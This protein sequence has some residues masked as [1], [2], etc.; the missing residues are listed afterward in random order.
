MCSRMVV[1]YNLGRAIFG[2]LHSKVQVSNQCSNQAEEQ[3][4]AK[5]MRGVGEAKGTCILVKGEIDLASELY[6][7]C[8]HKT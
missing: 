3:R 4:A 8:T 7:V 5:R 6:T 1:P 2:K